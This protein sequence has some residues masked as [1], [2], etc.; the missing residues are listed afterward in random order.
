MT[1]K[2]DK[3]LQPSIEKSSLSYTDPAGR[4]IRVLSEKDALSLADSSRVPLKE[5]Y[6]AALSIGIWPFRYVRN[7]EILSGSEQLKLLRS[8]VCIVGAGGLGGN[9]AMLLG[10]VG[11][12]RITS[13]DGDLF[14]E[15]NLNR[16]AAAF[17]HSIGKEKALETASLIEAINPSVEV[18]GIRTRITRENG[19]EILSGAD[20]MVDALDNIKD[21]FVLQALSRELKIP[22]VHGA[23]AGFEGQVMTIFPEDNGLESIYGDPESSQDPSTRPE[24]VLGVPP[25]TAALVATH[26]AMEVLKILLGRGEPFRNKMLYLDLETG[27]SRIYKFL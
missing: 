2:Q 21:R 20:V 7:R 17:T 25:M 1:E 12:G 11:I 10:R 14:D 6:E 23:L 4:K 9:V 19:A 24:A 5:V 16:Q 13:V 15:T 18:R 27:E 22:L 3:H 26:Q 8:S